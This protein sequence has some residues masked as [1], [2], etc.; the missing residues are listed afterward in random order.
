MLEG[1]NSLLAATVVFVGG[2]FFLSSL[3]VRAWVTDRLGAGGFRGLYSLVAGGS[4]V[5]ML[6]AYGAAPYIEIWPEL[7][8]LR[9]IVLVAMPIA[10]VL[11]VCGLTTRSPTAIGGEALLD[12]PQVPIPGIL[13]VTRHP[14]L[15][16]VA[17][18]AASHLMV[19]GDAASVILMGGF[20]VLTL[21]GMQH[22]D[23]RREATLGAAWGPIKLRSSAIP[24]AALLSRRTEMDWSGFGWWRPLLGLVLYAV[25]LGGHTYFFGVSP[26]PLALM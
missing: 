5:W 26:F 16:G 25:F 8:A 17:I 6:I 1:I 15:W 12:T 24:F 23:A 7:L 10:F 4:L 2:H 21:G 20:L 9:W 19:N 13:R 3:P 18:W 22:I 14:A 11:V